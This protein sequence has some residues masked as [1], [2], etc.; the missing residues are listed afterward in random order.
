[1]IRSLLNFN[2][3]REQDRPTASH[4]STPL[5][6]TADKSVAPEFEKVRTRILHNYRRLTRFTA[7]STRDSL[8]ALIGVT[9]RLADRDGAVELRQIQD[10]IDLLMRSALDIEHE[11][12]FL[13]RFLGIEKL[14]ESEERES[15][16]VLEVVRTQSAVLSS[17]AKQRHVFLDVWPAEGSLMMNGDRR[18]IEMLIRS[19]VDLAISRSAERSRVRVAVEPLDEEDRYDVEI[20]VA[21]DSGQGFDWMTGD[22][23]RGAGGL[24]RE[25]SALGFELEVLTTLA[26][27]VGGE[28]SV[29]VEPEVSTTYVVQLKDDPE[30]Y[31]PFVSRQDAAPVCRTFEEESKPHPKTGMNPAIPAMAAR[32]VREEERE[33]ILIIEDSSDFRYYLRSCLEGTYQVLEAVHGK[34][35]LAMAREHVPDLII[36]DVMMPYMDGHTLCREVKRDEALN[37][38]PIILSTALA[39]SEYRL[40]G[41]RAGADTYLVKPFDCKILQAQVKNLLENRRRLRSHYS[42]RILVE[43]TQI[44]V[45]AVDEVFLQRVK[46]I[47]EEEMGSFV[48]N[49]SV[50]AHKMHVCERQLQ[51]K[52]KTVLGMSPMEYVRIMKLKRAAQLLEQRAGNVSEVAFQVGYRNPRTFTAMFSK[53][54]GMSPTEYM[55]AT[56]TS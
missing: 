5:N 47:V 13:Q 24:S 21:D 37:H 26:H 48:F 43:P 17:T 19:V 31:L 12:D 8:A 30:E 38:I 56:G 46:S 27:A 22:G 3:K 40:Q 53:H 23:A 29:F 34:E 11:L 7:R 35:G 50:F 1:M 55:E 32:P 16:D 9:G 42:Q 52:F 20:R 49:L 25:V 6:T 15:F 51:R 41:L 18:K 2:A 14:L 33:I 4:N 10:E 54:F 36:S 39:A 28:L 44:S 45:P